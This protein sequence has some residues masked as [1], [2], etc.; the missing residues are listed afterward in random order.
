[1]ALFTITYKDD[2]TQEDCTL[3][4]VFYSSGFDGQF[5]QCYN[6]MLFNSI[7]IHHYDAEWSQKFLS[8][9]V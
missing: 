3:G 5:H 2:E 9:L 4:Q 1:M 6:L 7:I 8:K